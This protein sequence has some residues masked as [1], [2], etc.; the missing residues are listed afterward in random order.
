MDRRHSPTPLLALHCGGAWTARPLGASG[1]C[2]TWRAEG[3]GGPLFIKALPAAQAGTLAAE[4]DGLE[5]LRATRTIDVPAVIGC[6]TDDVQGLTVLALQWLDLD[7]AHADFGERFGRALAA[8]HASTRTEDDGCFGWGRDNFLG[9][10]PQSNDWSSEGGVAGWTSFFGR[11]RLGAMR[12]R[13]EDKGAPLALASTIDQVIAVLPA[14]FDDG[15]VP[16]PSLVHGDLWSGNWG[17]TSNGAPVIYDPAVSKSDAEAEL[18]MM[19]LFGAPPEGFWRAY[20]DAA[21]LAPGYARRR[22]LYQLYHLLNH[23][24]LFGG[25]AP[26]AMTVMQ[27]L[28]R[29]AGA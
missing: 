13:L 19:E 12:A 21:G 29:S 2:A 1:F 6:W 4:A 23:E 17:S 28:L 15:Y 14:F 11:R 8:L 5:A 16:R 10:T 27:Q 7:P 25:Y 3:P 24:L 26:R 18:A 22:D 9:A 20:R